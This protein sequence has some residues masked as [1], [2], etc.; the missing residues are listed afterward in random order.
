M[1]S[2]DLSLMMCDAFIQFTDFETFFDANLD[3]DILI[4]VR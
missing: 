3:P 1:S 4:E 2:N